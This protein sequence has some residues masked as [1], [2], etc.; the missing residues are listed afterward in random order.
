MSKNKPQLAIVR[1]GD[2]VLLQ[3]DKAQ[4][5]IPVA[6]MIKIL[7]GANPAQGA[8]TG[9]DLIPRPPVEILDSERSTVE[10][11][12]LAA[13]T[14]VYAFLRAEY[15]DEDNPAHN[16]DIGGIY[17]YLDGIK[18]PT[19]GFPTPDACRANDL[20]K[21]MIIT[22]TR[23]LTSNWLALFSFIRP[24][25][26]KNLI[27]RMTEWAYSISSP[28]YLKNIRYNWSLRELRVF[29]E[30]FFESTGLGEVNTAKAFI[31]ILQYDN[32]YL[33]RFQDLLN[34]TTQELLRDRPIREIWRLISILKERD[35]RAHLIDKFTSFAKI[36]SL[37]LL[38]PKYRR[39]YKRA[40]DKIDIKRIQMDEADRYL[41]LRW[42]GYKFLGKTDE[43]RREM[44][45]DAHGGVEN[46]PKQYTMQSKPQ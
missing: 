32:A 27:K 18:Y 21:R 36:G 14:P 24:K 43:E 3:V 40:L 11:V 45:E 13:P 23:V 7:Q 22:Q 35:N 17:V 26:V 8:A 44:F 19:K 25:N 29:L 1:K 15:P 41:V 6:Q 16:G 46:L 33:L 5:K 38:I 20:V 28:Y 37:L 30:D 9:D 2:S 39:A 10:H 34:E 12:M 4:F 42:A 31:N